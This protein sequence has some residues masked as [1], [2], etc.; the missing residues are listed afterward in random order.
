MRSAP[1]VRFAVYVLR[2]IGQVMLQDNF[3]T[4]F[5]FLVG[6]FV[7]SWVSGLYA[8]LGTVVSTWTAIFLKAPANEVD[9]GIYG[10]NGTLTGL[11]L[12]AYLSHGIALIVFVIIASMFV[13]LTTAAIRHI[14]GPRGHALTAPFVITTWIFLGALIVYL[15]LPNAGAAEPLQ[16]PSYAAALTRLSAL[17]VIL[18]ILNGP[19]QVM[20]QENP[21][22]G[23]IFLV[24][25]AFNS[26]VSCLAAL[27]GSAI[28]VGVG[29]YMGGTP[30]SIHQ[31]LFG[32]NGV[33]TAIVLGGILFL[34]NRT[35]VLLTV[36][37][38]YVST[39]L[40]GSLVVILKPLALPALTAPFVLVTW[41]YVLA[42][43]KFPR[44]ASLVVV[45]PGTPEGNLRAARD[46]LVEKEQGEVP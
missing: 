29:W 11:A 36:L 44:L 24:A 38:V 35:T 3:I 43:A 41:V 25:I 2:G 4:G 23:A 18:G 14:A 5:L 19:A 16:Q 46:P 6:I 42:C 39:V 1:A 45:S 21:W 9:A 22:T 15:G 17:D 10:F 12:A 32:F 34:L 33:L 40:F 27:L 26:R 31:G 30:H 8:L 13:A 20:L 37:G 28:G 7:S